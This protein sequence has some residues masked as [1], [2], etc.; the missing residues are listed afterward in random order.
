MPTAGERVVGKNQWQGSNEGR[1]MERLYLVD[2]DG[3][4]SSGIKNLLSIE[5]LLAL[6]TWQRRWLE[7]DGHAMWSNPSHQFLPMPRVQ[8]N[9]CERESEHGLGVSL[10]RLHSNRT[11][12]GSIGIS[13]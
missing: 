5:N 7:C 13:S 3:P 2:K 6:L 12:I 8:T 4:H 10:Q 11:C 1:T 9:E